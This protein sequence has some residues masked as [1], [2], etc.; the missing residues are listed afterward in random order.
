MPNS[1]GFI[2]RI[3]VSLKSPRVIPF[4]SLLLLGN[5]YR[6]EGLCDIMGRAFKLGPNGEGG[7]YLSSASPSP[8]DTKLPGDGGGRQ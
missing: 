1:A 8:G 6:P 4:K 7:D 5:E 2:A 3:R